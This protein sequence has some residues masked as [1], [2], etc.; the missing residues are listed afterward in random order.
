MPRQG[1]LDA[2]GAVHHVMTRGM[3][4]GRIFRDKA[5]Y[6]EFLGRFTRALEKSDA[7]CLA[8]ALLPNHIHLVMQTGTRPLA[9]VLH[10]VFG[11]YAVYFNLRWNRAGH[12]FQGRYQSVLCEKEKYLHELVRYVHLNPLRAGLVDT[13]AGLSRYPWSGHRTLLGLGD[14]RWQDVKG[15]LESFDRQPA[16]ARESYLAFLE[17]GVSS[18]AET[19]LPDGGF[20]RLVEGGW[21]K[22]QTGRPGDERVVGSG[23]FVER[24]LKLTEERERWRSR[25]RRHGIT[26]EVVLRRVAEATDVPVADLNGAS[27]TPARVKARALACYWLVDRFGWSEVAVAR[28]LGITQS[29]V[30][31][32][33][34]RGQ[35]L[36]STVH[37]RLPGARP[38]PTRIA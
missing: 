35:V 12:V 18:T 7:R 10:G 29:A 28:R 5:D 8:W 22:P 26:L 2:P 21:E 33:V 23:S 9:K 1:R 25:A 24:A 34:R 4:K 30:S 13:L 31:R 19:G 15:A 32:G 16:K 14:H 3:E 38:I 11:G 27:K 36:A 37:V 17:A 20:R 6:L